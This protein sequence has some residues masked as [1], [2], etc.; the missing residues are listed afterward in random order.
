MFRSQLHWALPHW[1]QKAEWPSVL[2]LGSVDCPLSQYL[3]APEAGRIQ[4]RSSDGQVHNQPQWDLTFGLRIGWLGPQFKA[5]P[6]SDTHYW[7]LYGW[8][9]CGDMAGHP[10]APRQSFPTPGWHTHTAWHFSIR[11]GQI[12]VVYM[13]IFFATHCQKASLQTMSR[14]RR[15]CCTRWERAQ[16]WE[17]P[18]WCSGGR[19]NSLNLRSVTSVRLCINQA[20]VSLRVLSVKSPLLP[21]SSTSASSSETT[22]TASWARSSGRWGLAL[23][24]AASGF[25]T[26]MAAAPGDTSAQAT[27]SHR[28]QLSPQSTSSVSA[29]WAGPGRTVRR[30]SDPRQ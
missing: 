1:D 29:T 2:A 10:V 16:H 19:W 11:C 27:P 25:A 14:S 8:P 4:P 28:A 7:K 23:N 21:S 24:S 17:L 9:L 26:A 12:K 6:L 5:L 15:T 3:P 18:A 13:P 30:R 22:Y 20:F